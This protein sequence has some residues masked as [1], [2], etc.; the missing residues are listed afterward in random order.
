MVRNV[1]RLLW[2]PKDDTIERASLR[3]ETQYLE[4]IHRQLCRNLGLRYP[5]L[6]KFTF[7]P[8]YLP[9]DIQL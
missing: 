7:C 5:W 3:I 2:C 9:N 8:K 1:D 6:Y 4:R